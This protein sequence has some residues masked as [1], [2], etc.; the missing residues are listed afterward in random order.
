MEKSNAK[1]LWHIIMEH[2]K[3]FIIHQNLICYIFCYDTKNFETLN[4]KVF[5]TCT[6]RDL[7]SFVLNF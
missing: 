5:D 7:S 4:F 1:C 3:A 2:T 6:Q